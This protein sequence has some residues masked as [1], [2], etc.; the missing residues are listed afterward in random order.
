MSFIN[1]I[2]P[3]LN[4]K[5]PRKNQ[6]HGLDL[7]VQYELARPKPKVNTKHKPGYKPNYI[8]KLPIGRTPIPAQRIIEEQSA[9][10]CFSKAF[11]VKA[12]GNED[13]ITFVNRCRSAVIR[14]FKR[15]RS[16]KARLIL[17]CLMEIFHINTSGSDTK[18]VQFRS[19]SELI[20]L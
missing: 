16:V 2:I 7:C 15:Q 9:L 10:T 4:I 1:E 17:H 5:Q 8:F 20:L 18:E 13:D 19:G 11:T 3:L 6:V 14:L 12:Y